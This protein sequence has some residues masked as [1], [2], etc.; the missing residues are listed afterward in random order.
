ML[1]ALLYGWTDKSLVHSMLQIQGA[2]SSGHVS[3]VTAYEVWLTSKHLALVMELAAG[4]ALTDYV[5]KRYS[6]LQKRG[7]LYLA[8]AEARY[9]FYQV[10]PRE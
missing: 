8:E 5:T 6:S 9:F 10:D 3:I 1:S 7:G 4:G 2:I